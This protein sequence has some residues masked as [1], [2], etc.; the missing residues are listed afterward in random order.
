MGRGR[1]FSNNWRCPSSFFPRSV[2]TAQANGKVHE[3]WK[4]MK[5]AQETQASSPR[6]PPSCRRAP[7]TPFSLVCWLT[8]EAPLGLDSPEG[9]REPAAP[10][11]TA[12][13]KSWRWVWVWSRPFR[14]QYL[15]MT[16][17][18]GNKLP[19]LLL[20][21]SSTANHK[22]IHKCLMLKTTHPSAWDAKEPPYPSVFIHVQELHFW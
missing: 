21:Q 8:A 15:E 5:T 3:D 17:T 6:H 7:R 10:F 16:H 4:V 22:F 20:L 11:Y 13:P 14:S 12:D 9:G 18:S 2:R 1:I 19:A